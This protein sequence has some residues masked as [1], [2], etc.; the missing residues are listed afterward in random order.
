[1]R[2][3]HNLLLGTHEGIDSACSKYLLDLVQGLAKARK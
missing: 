2:T 1:M 3:T